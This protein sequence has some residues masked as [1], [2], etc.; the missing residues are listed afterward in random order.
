[1]RGPKGRRGH[2]GS[3]LEA[4]MI[5]GP[6][7]RGERERESAFGK[8]IGVS[9][10]AG[11]RARMDSQ[12]QLWASCCLYLVEKPR[13]AGNSSLEGCSDGL[14]WANGGARGHWRH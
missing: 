4:C 2:L 9:G 8:Q 3:S 13:E 11:E 5:L 10:G 14:G 6:V 1:M 7:D 12:G